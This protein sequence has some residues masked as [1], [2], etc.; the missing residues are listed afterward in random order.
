MTRFFLTAFA[1]GALAFSTHATAQISEVRAGVNLHDIDWTGL[2]NGRDKERSVAL[3]GEI[4]FEEPEFLKWALTPQPYIGG[5]LNLEGETSY[6]GAGL[7]WR[8]TFG[9]GF[10]FDFSFGLVAHDGNLE[11]KPS[12]FIV[13]VTSGAIPGPYS[14]EQ[15]ERF[16]ADF[17]A[18]RA[19]Q[20]STI[21]YGSRI[22][23]REQFALGYRWSDDWSAHIFVEH[24]SHGN[25][26]VQGKPNEGLD[27][28]G[29]RL[30]R[31]Y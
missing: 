29:V 2:G 11:T 7:L 5:A 20:N 8:Q 6:G 31:H 10:Y 1:A 21:D 23:F 4:V 9:E 25:I 30:S 13:D 12:Q 3:N 16:N 27:T 19:E 24:L 22:L 18:F 17:A 28:L 15:V 14:R 26:L